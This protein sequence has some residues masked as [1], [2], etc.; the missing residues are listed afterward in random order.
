M[1]NKYVVGRVGVLVREK[2]REI[3]EVEKFIFL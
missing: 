2:R 3:G 1:G